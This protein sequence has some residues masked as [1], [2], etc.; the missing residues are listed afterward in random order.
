MQFFIDYLTAIKDISP[1]DKEIT[2]RPALK[3]F[4]DNIKSYL[5]TT[6]N[7]FASITIHHEPNNDKDGF[8]APDFHIYT[9]GK[10]GGGINTRLYRK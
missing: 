2:H 5:A 9:L 6:Q 10:W 1:Q 4:L 3:T 8:G 7:G